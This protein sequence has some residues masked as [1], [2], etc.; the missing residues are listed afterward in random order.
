MKPLP[1]LRELRAFEAAARLLS[2]RKAAEE[3]AVTP[4]AISHQ[5]RLLERFCGQP[6]FQRRP[7][8]LALTSAGA[9]LSPVVSAA[10][11]AMAEE[12]ARVHD[13]TCG[14]HLKITAT[15]AFAAR[16][17]VPRLA[18]WRAKNPRI[19]LD[20]LGTNAVLN[21]MTGEVDVAIRYAR[22]P[23]ADG[24]SVEIMHDQFLAV[25]NPQLISGRKLPLSPAD[26]AALPLI[27]LGWPASDPDAPTWRRWEAEVCARSLAP[28]QFSTRPA[29]RFQ[30]ELHVI[31]AIIGGHGLGLCSDVLVGP[32]LASGALVRV[33]EITLPGYGYHVVWR[34][35]HPR[36]REIEVFAGWAS[37]LA[38]AAPAAPTES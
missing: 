8:P 11:N 23:P 26:I 12:L 7:R 29:L 1:P 27:E 13:R 6:L 28:P 14:V 37:A 30:E 25:A 17:I 10:F 19:A 21:L 33:S 2:F 5:I 20:I 24:K 38:G 36:R 35:E 4:T 32:E 16:W 31:E 18:N 9:R 15:N 22:N 34:A 3:L